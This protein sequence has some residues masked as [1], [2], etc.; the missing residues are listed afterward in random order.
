MMK[1][2]IFIGLAFFGVILGVTAFMF[3]GIAVVE[4]LDWW[5]DYIRSLR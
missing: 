5:Q 4:L 2:A 1:D 3:F